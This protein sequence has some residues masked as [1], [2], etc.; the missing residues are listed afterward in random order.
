MMSPSKSWLTCVSGPESLIDLR[1]MWE[2]I[3][4]YFH[5]ICA[6]YHG[7]RE[8]EE[9]L[10]LE[11]SKK[12]GMIIYLPYV[13]R[14]SDSRN[15]ALHCGKI[16]DGD[17]VVQT[18]TLER[19]QPWF[20]ETIKPALIKDGRVNC[21][22]YYGKPFLFQYHESLTYRGT[23]HEGLFRTD[24]KMMAIELAHTWPDES[25]MRLNVRPLKR[26]PTHFID[27]FARYFLMP[28]GS[29]H[30]L[31][32][33]EKNGDPNV[34]Y[35][36]REA[37]RLAFRDEMRRRGF[38]LTL[39]GLKRMLSGSIDTKL[40][41]MIQSDKVWSDWF[42]HHIKGRKDVVCS[43]DDRDMIKDEIP[44]DIEGQPG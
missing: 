2:P 12:D 8:D 9:A 3:K 17:W 14:H 38:P 32:G 23:P 44:V 41:D 1:E 36:I 7:K 22:L 16:E 4:Q 20:L 43:H 30:A 21:C 35:P 28:W 42:F 18:D 15:I 29:N 27:H 34:L 40:R 26:P 13:G 25:K 19:P 33:L 31:L 10:Y 37:K 39:D 24:G 6:I 11:S 5:G